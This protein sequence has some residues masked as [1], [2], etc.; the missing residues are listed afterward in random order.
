M[1]EEWF[2]TP[3]YVEDGACRGVV[4]FELITGELHFVRAKAVIVAAGGLGR[5]FE[6]STNAVICTGDGYALRIAQA[7]R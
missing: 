6:P 5:V 3:L 2:A 4:A 1:Y 7:R